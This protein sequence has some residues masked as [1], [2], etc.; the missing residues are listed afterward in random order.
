MVL[1]PHPWQDGQWEPI[2]QQFQCKR[3]PIDKR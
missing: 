1:R 3:L 2:R